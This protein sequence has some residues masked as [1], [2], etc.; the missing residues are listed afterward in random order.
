[1]TT[2]L[3]VEK[4]CRALLDGL[5]RLLGIADHRRWATARLDRSVQHTALPVLHCFEAALR[6]CDGA[7][8]HLR[9]PLAA[10]GASL[11]WRRNSAY[12]NADFVD[13]Y[14]YCELLGPTGHVRD[15]RLALGLLLLAPGITY[16]WHAHPARETYA[17]V[18]GRAQWR[19]G[20]AP[21]RVRSPGDRIEHASNEPHAMRTIDQPLL[22][23]Y[24]WHDHLDLP[25]RLTT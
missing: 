23:A 24:V 12:A 17:V 25:A 15:A 2:S 21:W 20:D 10:V 13:G 22:A 16:P 14:G 18:A 9:A 11:H 4:Q 3:A 19:Q 8:A 6:L 1:L 7:T 5:G